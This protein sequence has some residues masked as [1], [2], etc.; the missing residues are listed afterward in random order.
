MLLLVQAIFDFFDLDLRQ[1]QV[2]LHLLTALIALLELTLKFRLLSLHLLD[3]GSLIVV[4]NLGFAELNF[5]ATSLLSQLRRLC[6]I[7]VD[8]RKQ[9]RVCLARFIKLPLGFFQLSRQSSTLQFLLHHELVERLLLRRLLLLL[10]VVRVL[11]L[12]LVLT[13]VE[14]A[15]DVQ[16]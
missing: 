5:L 3:R 7:L 2:V 1:C 6:L 11:E 8:L 16:L 14:E 13:H 9:L 4:S 10:L 12:R 15:G